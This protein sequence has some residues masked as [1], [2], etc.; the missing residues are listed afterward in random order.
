MR[1]IYIDESGR[2]N[3]FYFFGGLVVDSDSL[4]HIDEQMEALATMLSRTLPGFASGTEFHAV[5]MFQ[6]TG[7]WKKIPTVWRVRACT[8][9]SSILAGSGAQFVFRGINISAHHKNYRT[10]YPTHLLALA[11]L[12]ESLDNHLLR[13]CGADTGI[14]LADEHHTATDSRR[15]L[16]QF[17]YTQV[18]GYVSHPLRQIQDTLYFGP[19]HAS[20]LL[21]AADVATYFLNRDR[22]MRESTAGAAAAVSKIAAKIRFITVTEAV[23][24]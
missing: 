20:R 16:A 5:E 14:V 13:R 3:S 17:K 10:P 8:I 7:A 21:Q 6:G 18:P 12:L 9:I 22:T 23:W 2:D 24:P 19:S 4:T 11:Q 15:N 1:A